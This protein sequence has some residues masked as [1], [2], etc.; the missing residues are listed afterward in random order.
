MARDSLATV[1]KLTKMQK[2]EFSDLTSVNVMAHWVREL[3]S[4]PVS[5]SLCMSHRARQASM[6]RRVISIYVTC[7]QLGDVRDLTCS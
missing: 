6:R 2:S 3:M 5:A 1:K 7:M 4:A